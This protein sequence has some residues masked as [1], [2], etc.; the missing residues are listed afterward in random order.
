MYGK[1]KLIGNIDRSEK[2]INI[3]N[4]NYI[5]I[6]GL[7]LSNLKATNSEQTPTAIN[8]D[9]HSKSIIIKNNIIQHKLI[10]FLK[11]LLQNPHI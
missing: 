2:I 10:K 6:S 1:T 5:N 8:I 7:N 9:G 4:S 11:I 3:R